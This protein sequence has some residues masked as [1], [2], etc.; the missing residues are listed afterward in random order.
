MPDSAIHYYQLGE[1]YSILQNRMD[2]VAASRLRI[3]QIYGNE[4]NF[5][6][7]LEFCLR[8]FEI[9]QSEGII[10]RQ[11]SC[12]ECIYMSYENLGNK[13]KAY[14]YLVLDLAIRDSLISDEE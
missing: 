3:G 11:E 9:L 14:D 8:A 2:G 13:Q 5:E 10:R 4:G 6:K 12:T 7:S 1:K